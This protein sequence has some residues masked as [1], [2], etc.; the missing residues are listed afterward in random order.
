MDYRSNVALAVKADKIKYF[1]TTVVLKPESRDL[2]EA[3]CLEMFTEFEDIDDENGIL[4]S[5]ES[6]KWYTRYPDV[7]LIN[8]F[9]EE[10]DAS[11][12]SGSYYFI[13]VGEEPEDIETRGGWWTNS[14]EARVVSGY[15]F[16]RPNP[17]S[18]QELF[19]L[20][21]KRSKANENRY[22]EILKEI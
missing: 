8:A 12:L 22:D 18:T 19:D 15:T 5:W 4:F 20:D 7:Q 21:N 6:I 14:F 10:L 13:K 17:I 16:N 2:F 9:M 3:N 11:N 1:L